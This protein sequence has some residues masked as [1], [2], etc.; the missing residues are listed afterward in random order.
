MPFQSSRKSRSK[1]GILTSIGQ[2]IPVASLNGTLNVPQLLFMPYSNFNGNTSF[3]YQ[4]NDGNLYSNVAV[5]TLSIASVNDDPTAVND[6]LAVSQGIP[7]IIGSAELFG[8][9]K[10][11]GSVNDSDVDG[12]LFSSIKITLLPPDG[13]LLLNG[14]PVTLNQV[15]SYADIDANGLTFVSTS[16]NNTLSIIYHHP[17]PPSLT[18]INLPN[19][20]PPP[21]PP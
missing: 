5:A 7:I 1:I 12:G 2:E 8:S 17:N 10:G 15:I 20:P 11:T 13:T 4:V 9:D 6:L 14:V 18:T 21:P 3:Q 19:H 16:A